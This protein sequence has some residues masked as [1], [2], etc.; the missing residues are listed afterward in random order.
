MQKV[1][2]LFSGGL[3]AASTLSVVIVVIYGANLTIN[4]YM[5]TG[6]LTS[7]ILY[8]LTGTLHGFSIG[9][10]YTEPSII[11]DFVTANSKS[12]IN[13]MYIGWQ[14]WICIYNSWSVDIYKQLKPCVYTVGS[15]VSALSGLYTTVMKA[16][17]ASR[18]VFQLLDRVSSMPNSGDKCPIKL[19][20]LSI[21]FLE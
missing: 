5:T 14:I 9:N 16:S 21:S 8:S 15:S 17:G 4:G 13:V 20:Y 11:L 19:V 2:G 1:V 10:I 3:N 12:A 18:R 7:F 6:S